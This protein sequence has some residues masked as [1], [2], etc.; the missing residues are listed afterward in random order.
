MKSRLKSQWNRT[1]NRMNGSEFFRFFSL[2]AS[3]LRVVGSWFRCFGQNHGE[4]WIGPTEPRIIHDR[5][6][7]GDQQ[8]NVALFVCEVLCLMYKIEFMNSFSYVNYLQFHKDT[9]TNNEPTQKQEFGPSSNTDW[10]EW[11]FCKCS[12]GKPQRA[13]KAYLRVAISYNISN[14]ASQFSK[15]NVGS[16]SNTVITRKDAI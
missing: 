9:T 1:W 13:A 5:Y 10:G 16:K 15:E 6:P 4:L 11:L 2:N 8:M 7:D 12:G 14:S 3:A